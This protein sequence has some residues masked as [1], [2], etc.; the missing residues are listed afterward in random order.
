VTL[1]WSHPDA[2]LALW[3]GL[4][5]LS[6]TRPNDI[7]PEYGLEAFDLE[8]QEAGTYTFEVRRSADENA[9]LTPVTAQLVVIWNEGQEDEQIELVELSFDRERTTYA[10]TLSG[11]TLTPVGGAR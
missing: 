1:V 7:T 11:R 8:E 5:G 10:W 2:Q 9:E 6:A 3:G 4:P